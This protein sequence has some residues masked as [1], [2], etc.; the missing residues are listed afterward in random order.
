MTEVAEAHYLDQLRTRAG[1]DQRHRGR[2][3]RLR[4]APAPVPMIEAGHPIPDAAG[5]EAAE[6]ALAARRRRERGRSGAGTD[7]GRR[8]GELDRAG[9]GLSLEDKQAVTRALL[10]SGAAIGEINTVRKH[11]SRIKGGRLARQAHPASLVTLAISD[12]PGDDPAAIGSG[13]TVPD[14]TTLADARAIVARYNLDM[15]GGIARALDDPEK[16]NA[17]AGRL[18]FRRQPVQ[19]GRA[20]GGCLARGRG[21]GARGRL[22]MRFARR[23][24]R[25]RSARGCR[26]PRPPRARTAARRATAP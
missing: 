24:G 20:A 9:R 1:P 17:E 26:R 16:R 6:H 12:V 18:R 2:A 15:P 7:V 11:L 25:R 21:G 19:A 4:P 13:P 22:R 10:R 23:P 5:L 3:S 14:P 8:I